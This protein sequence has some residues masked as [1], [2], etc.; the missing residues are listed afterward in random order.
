MILS[1]LVGKVST[2]FL[3][4]NLA[5]VL[6]FKDPIKT[7]VFGGDSASLFAQRVNNERTL[8]L[9][10]NKKGINSNLLVVTKS[11]QYNFYVKSDEKNPH[12]FIQVVNA[13]TSGSSRT[14]QKT[15]LFEMREGRG[16]ILFKNNSSFVME[17]NKESLKAGYSTFIPKGAPVILNGKRIYN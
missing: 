16:F 3:S 1:N 10:P 7:T 4:V 2:I 15:N 9:K 17:V 5:T 13:T 14:I 11:N 8:I 6:T 12:D